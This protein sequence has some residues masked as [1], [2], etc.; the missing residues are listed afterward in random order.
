M[1]SGRAKNTSMEALLDH[2]H[3]RA[4]LLIRQVPYRFRGSF[5]SFHG[6]YLNLCT[7]GSMEAGPSLYTSVEAAPN[8]FYITSTEAIGFASMEYC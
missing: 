8:V 4:R 2:F 7:E 3:G 1:E 6:S 5:Y